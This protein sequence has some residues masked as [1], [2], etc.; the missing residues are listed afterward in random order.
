MARIGVVVL[1]GLRL[2]FGARG[3]FVA[4]ATVSLAEQDAVEPQ[5]SKGRCWTGAGLPVPVQHT[6]CLL[7]PCDSMR[8]EQKRQ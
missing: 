4:A 8:L 7:P 5:V 1:P 6:S 3:S 2:L